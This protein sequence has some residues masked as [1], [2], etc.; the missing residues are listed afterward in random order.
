MRRDRIP[1]WSAQDV[2]ECGV[3]LAVLDRI[4]GD[5]RYS[6]SPVEPDG[7]HLCYDHGSGDH[8]KLWFCPSGVL[9][10]GF[11]HESPVSPY[12]SN[13]LWPGLYTGLPEG[14]KL[15]VSRSDGEAELFPNEEGQPLMEATWALWRPKGSSSWQCGPVKDYPDHPAR[16]G[17][18]LLNVYGLEHWNEERGIDEKQL[19]PF[20]DGQPVS[21]EDI[22]GINSQADLP[23]VRKLM[24]DLLYGLKPAW[25]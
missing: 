3:G 17:A 20:F 2:W 15:W 4:A 21:D 1:N 11:D 16:E 12:A 19:V 25:L 22:L 14:L 8:L 24:S 13:S 9:M 6:M 23:K 7:F 5:D 18:W 10:T